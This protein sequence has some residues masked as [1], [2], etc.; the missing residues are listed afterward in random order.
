MKKSLKFSKKIEKKIK[1]KKKTKKSIHKKYKKTYKKYFGGTEDTINEE[2]EDKCGICLESGYPLAT[3]YDIKGEHPHRFHRDCISTWLSKNRTCPICRNHIETIDDL[4]IKACNQGDLNLVSTLINFKN[5]NVNFKIPQTGQTALMI[6]SY[7][8]NIDVVKLLL[9]HGAYVNLK[10][11][12]GWTSLM[13][14]SDKGHDDIAHLLVEANANV[15]AKDNTGYTALMFASAGN[16][17]ALVKLMIDAGADVNAET[18]SGMT[19]IMLTEN[20]SCINLLKSK[21]ATPYKIMSF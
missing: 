6:A 14:A 2:V 11:N 15:D 3:L 5:A 8:N 18:N 7:R 19:A 1:F 21:G 4:F 17:V 16:N 20:K 10:D 13:I 12:A 9:Y